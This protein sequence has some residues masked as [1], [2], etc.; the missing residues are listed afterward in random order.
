MGRNAE[1]GAH[2]ERLAA[3]YL[4]QHG[5]TILDRNWRCRFGEIDIVARDG[6]SLV[7]CEVKTRSTLAFGHPAEAVTPRKLRRM[8]HLAVQWLMAHDIHAPLVR[9]DVV[10]VVPALHG[11]ASIEHIRAADHGAV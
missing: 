4:E 1:L 3:A 11:P 2:G 10:C 9:L 8:R 5:L 7:V 6:A